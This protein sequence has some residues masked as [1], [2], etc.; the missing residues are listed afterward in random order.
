MVCFVVETVFPEDSKRFVQGRLHRILE[1][2]GWI[3]D[4]DDSLGIAMR[5]K[6]L[7][8]AE[9][10]VNSAGTVN[11]QHVFNFRRSEVRVEG[12]FINIYSGQHCS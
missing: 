8:N 3:G 6:I 4:R 10:V 12:Y 1:S 5:N 11:R 7:K 2:K 9:K